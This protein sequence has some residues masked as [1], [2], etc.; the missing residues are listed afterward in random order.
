MLVVMVTSD[1]VSKGFDA[2]EIIKTGSEI[3]GGGGIKKWENVEQYKK[4]GGYQEEIYELVDKY[5]LN[6]VDFI[7]KHKYKY[8]HRIILKDGVVPLFEL[9]KKVLSL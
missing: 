6:L 5:D 3:I 9:K 2:K 1:Q 8:N 4:M 7:G